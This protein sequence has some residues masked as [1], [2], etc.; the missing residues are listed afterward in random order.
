MQCPACSGH[1]LPIVSVTGQ[2]ILLSLW[3]S[4]AMSRMALHAPTP[5]PTCIHPSLMHVAAP[6]T[7][8]AQA[9][10]MPRKNKVKPCT[11]SGSSPLPAQSSACAAVP[12]PSPVTA[13]RRGCALTRRSE[14]GVRLLIV[15]VL[16]AGARPRQRL[17]RVVALLVLALGR[18]QLLLRGAARSATAPSA[19]YPYTN[20][21]TLCPIP[22]LGGR[23]NCLHSTLTA[24][25]PSA[26]TA[27]APG[28][29]RGLQESCHRGADA[30]F[31]AERACPGMHC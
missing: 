18:R 25:A 24:S 15:L 13:G 28:S 27:R 31:P 14:L 2:I 7:R 8:W 10:G 26:P 5:N 19:P 9:A 6:A 22:P 21:Y 29:P 1:P 3:A 16:V 12:V 4:E 23:I 17:G 30:S 11:C 20:P